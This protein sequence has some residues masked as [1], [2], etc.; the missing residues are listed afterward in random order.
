MYHQKPQS[1]VPQSNIIQRIVGHG[2]RRVA[3]EIALTL[4]IAFA[5]GSAFDFFGPLHDPAAE[6]PDPAQMQIANDF[7]QIAEAYATLGLNEASLRN[8]EQYLEI[9]GNL[10]DPAVASRVNVLRGAG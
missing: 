7:L 3:A 10:A 4:V 2:W 5:A 8:F 9:A 1:D 6:Q